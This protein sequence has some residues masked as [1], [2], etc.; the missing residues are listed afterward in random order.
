MDHYTINR[1]KTPPQP[2]IKEEIKELEEIASNRELIL[3][4]DFIS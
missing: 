2:L 3:R 4:N 1:Q